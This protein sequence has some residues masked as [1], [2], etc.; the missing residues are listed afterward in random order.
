MSPRVAAVRAEVERALS[1]LALNWQEGTVFTF[2]ARNPEHDDR[3]MIVTSDPDL[4]AVVTLLERHRTYT[5]P[6]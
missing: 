4:G 3:E 6:K 1:V 5:Q 2:I